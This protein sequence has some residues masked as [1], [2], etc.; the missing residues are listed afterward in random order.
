MVKV[1]VRKKDIND[2]LREPAVDNFFSQISNPRARIN[3]RDPVRI[4]A[5][6]PYAGCTS[7]VTFKFLPA[8]R[9]RTP[10]SIKFD[11]HIQQLN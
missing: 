2:M 1:K 5:V 10:H 4:V 3:D 8:Y 9:Q 11:F 7:A 6:D